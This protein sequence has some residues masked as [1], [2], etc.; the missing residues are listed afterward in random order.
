MSSSRKPPPKP[1]PMKWIVLSIVLFIAGYTAVNIYFRK[2]G[3]GYRPY[4]D[5]QDRA[6]TAR[7]LAAG[8][9]KL[10]VDTRRPLDQPVTD[11]PAAIRHE[12]AGLGPELSAK[13]AEKPRLVSSIDHVT[14]PARVTRGG[15][16]TVTFSATLS[17]LHTQVGDLSLYHR[18][19]EL[20]LVPS[21]ETLPGRELMSRWN[22]NIYAVS[23]STAD[24]PPGRYTMRIVAMAPAAAWQFTIK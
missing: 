8:W 3:P 19:Q 11:E 23:F 9:H 2:P 13:F 5:A 14:A 16:C 15:E 6:T 4:Q 18:G 22:D 7:L 1:W 12:I 20:V 24:L 21:L 10:P 17:Q